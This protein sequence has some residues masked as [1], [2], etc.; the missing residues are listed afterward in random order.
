LYEAKNESRAG[1]SFSA[2]CPFSNAAW[3]GWKNP[4]FGCFTNVPG[5]SRS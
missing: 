2:T 3:Y 4:P 1:P 5:C